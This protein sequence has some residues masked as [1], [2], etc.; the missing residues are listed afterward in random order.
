ML[1]TEMRWRLVVLRKAVFSNELHGPLY[2][3][4]TTRL[5]TRRAGCPALLLTP[6]LGYL[7]RHTPRPEDSVIVCGVAKPPR[8]LLTQRDGPT[9]VRWLPVNEPRAN[10][11]KAIPS[12]FYAQVRGPWAPFGSP[13]ALLHLQCQCGS[14]PCC[15]LYGPGRIQRTSACPPTYL[16]DPP[17][18][19]AETERLAKNFHDGAFS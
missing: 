3:K 17:S 1:G 2:L 7:P 16:S 14:L 11:S 18:L 19:S 8:R 10:Q 6:R 12:P 5:P 9:A 15:T 4:S 13:P